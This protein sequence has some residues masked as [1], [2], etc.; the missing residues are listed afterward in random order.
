MKRY[1]A[2]T[3]DGGSD[4]LGQVTQQLAR[5][6]SQMERV[7]RKIAICSGKGGVGKS[8]VTANLALAFS[9]R[10]YDVGV[11]DADLNGA[12][13]ARMLGVGGET[14]KVAPCGVLP[15]VA[16]MDI[17]VASMDL[18]LPREYAPLSWQG[19]PSHQF[20]WRG[21]M[22]AS[23]LREFLADVDWGELD[24][25]L[26]DMPP[27]VERLTDLADLLPELAGV[28]AVTIPS[29]VAR[30]VVGK[31][32]TRAMELKLPVLGVVENMAG[33]L[34]PHCGC[35]NSVFEG[36]ET[37][38]ELASHFG[39]PL[40]G[41]IPLDP[42][43]GT[44]TDGGIPFMVKHPDSPVAIAFRETAAKIWEAMEGG[45]R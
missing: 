23:A 9:G 6:R 32:L 45:Q 8:F 3:G 10:G 38:Q 29:T 27:G 30:A 44:A 5:L 28:I 11:L 21:T 2:I 24:L 31:C 39:V 20:V 26:L 7:G 1:Q 18:L 37:G 36:E 4:I 16:A 13:M 12:S 17:R 19:P 41:S 25:L 43:A 15:A 14:L 33:Y 22:E 34:C 42:G 40:L 35:R